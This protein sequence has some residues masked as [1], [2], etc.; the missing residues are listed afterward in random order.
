MSKDRLGDTQGWLLE[1]AVAGKLGALRRGHVLEFADRVSKNDKTNNGAALSL[2]WSWYNSRPDKDARHAIRAYLLASL[3][4]ND[5]APKDSHAEAERVKNKVKNWLLAEISSRI[6]TYLGDTDTR[7]VLYQLATKGGGTQRAT[8][9]CTRCDSN[10]GVELADRLGKGGN[11]G[12]VLIDMQGDLEKGG[13]IGQNTHYGGT[14]ALEHQQDVLQIA[15][16]LRAI[17]YDIVIDR[18]G[19]SEGGL[20][21]QRQRRDS[22]AE[23]ARIKTSPLLAQH[24]PGA[25]LRHIPK[26]SYPTF[27]GTLFAEHLAA[28]GVDTV[29]VMGYDANTCVAETVFGNPAK[30]EQVPLRPISDDEMRKYLDTHPGDLPLYARD[31]K[32]LRWK[33]AGG[34]KIETTQP[35]TIGLLDSNI[36]VIT[37]RAVLMCGSQMLRP[38]WGFLSEK[39]AT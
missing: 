3:Y 21:V 38:E 39:A 16:G 4:N 35:Y 5:I 23:A 31:P 9:T 36:K 2:D 27:F 15:A 11:V 1:N 8:A 10:V 14:T 19:A 7:A 32:A 29:I 6:L 13:D 26:P 37:S 17:V 20:T 18:D 12:V 34:S 25:Q 24:F 30:I 22:Y 28:D 33:I